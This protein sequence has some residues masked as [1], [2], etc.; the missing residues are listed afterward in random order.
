M[1]RLAGIP[2]FAK[3]E[4]FTEG[5][6]RWWLWRSQPRRRTNFNPTTREREAVELPANGLAPAF[7]RIGGRWF[8]DVDR[9]YDSPRS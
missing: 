6:V 1:A 7:V 9:F 8:V 3:D 4:G 2:K 5:Q